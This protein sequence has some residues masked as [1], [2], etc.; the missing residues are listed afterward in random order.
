MV[1]VKVVS[2]ARR[3]LGMIYRKF[4]FVCRTSTLYKAY[5]KPHLNY[6]SFTWDPPLVKDQEALESVQKC[7]LRHSCKNW[8][9]VY[10]KLLDSTDLT[11]L[12]AERKI[13]KLCFLYKIVTNLTS[14]FQGTSSGSDF[15]FDFTLGAC[16][17]FVCSPS[18]NWILLSFFCTYCKSW[19]TLPL[20]FLQSRTITALK[21]QLE[22]I[23][24]LFTCYTFT[25]RQCPRISSWG[26]WH[27]LYIFLYKSH[28]GNKILKATLWPNILW[29][30]APR[31][32]SCFCVLHQSFHKRCV[33]M[34]CPVA[35]AVSWLCHCLP[36]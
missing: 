20:H 24:Q 6:C 16:F 25:L 15:L 5:V 29:E 2:K 17:S 30:H 11:T 7:V 14:N 22:N 10:L 28:K 19:N 9:A 27:V 26:I 36:P 34:L 3:I 31:P 35:L 33:P 21:Y 23:L 12:N 4:Y 13:P 8:S 1:K 18:K 32:T